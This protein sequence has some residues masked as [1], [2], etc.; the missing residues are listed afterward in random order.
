[1]IEF[2]IADQADQ[3][4]ATTLNLQRV[5]LR[6][7]YNPI[8]DRWSFDLSVDGEAVLH[9]RRIV[10]GVDLLAPFDFGIGVIFALPEGDAEPGRSEL[11]DG[12]VK[13]YSAQ[14]AEVDAAIAA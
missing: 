12:R 13:L 7:R 6:L 3:K 9:G 4:F 11:P 5:S 2:E 8:I 14:D 1:M 10:T